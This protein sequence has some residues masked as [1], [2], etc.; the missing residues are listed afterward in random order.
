MF[1]WS[2]RVQFDAVLQNLDLSWTPGSID[3]CRPSQHRTTEDREEV[4][5]LC[6]ANNLTMNNE[7]NTH[8]RIKSIDNTF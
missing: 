1:I 5:L 4:I 2:S 3:E 6:L 8:L 7:N